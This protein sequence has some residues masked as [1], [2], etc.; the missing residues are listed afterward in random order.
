MIPVQYAEH[1]SGINDA[2]YNEN[3]C[4]LEAN[5]SDA[6]FNNVTMQ[7]CNNPLRCLRLL[8][9]AFGVSFCKRS[10]AFATA[11]MKRNYAQGERGAGTSGWLGNYRGRDFVITA[12]Q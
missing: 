2:G 6:R 9:K 1:Y 8:A 11:T 10:D 4:T 12:T 7:R 3:D 5:K